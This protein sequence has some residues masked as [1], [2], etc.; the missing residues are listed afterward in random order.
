MGETE[1][2]LAGARTPWPPDLDALR[3]ALRT[4]PGWHEACD[5]LQRLLSREGQAARARADDLATRFVGRRPVMIFRAV[6]TSGLRATSPFIEAACEAFEEG[7]AAAE[8]GA[9]ARGEV[10][11]PYRVRAD[12]V[13]AACDIAAGLVA[14]GDRHGLSDDDAIA[15]AWAE[16]AAPHELEPSGDRWVGALADVDMTILAWLRRASGADAVRPDRRLWDGSRALGFDLPGTWLTVEARRD[17]VIVATGAAHELGTDR[18]VLD[19][20]VPFVV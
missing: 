7:R 17:A 16:S 3:D 15:T 10:D 6:V 14:F 13:A 1:Q 4:T 19:E 5:R 12:K 8:L 18:N 9:L 11:D 20:V 2:V